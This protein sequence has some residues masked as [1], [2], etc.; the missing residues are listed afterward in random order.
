MGAREKI[1]GNR[2]IDP[3][4]DIPVGAVLRAAVQAKLQ[5]EGVVFPKGSYI[6]VGTP[7]NLMKAIKGNYRT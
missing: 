2:K 7:E 6:D 5:V 4:G 3:G 1:L